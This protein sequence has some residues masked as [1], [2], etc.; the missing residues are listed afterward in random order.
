MPAS[1]MVFLVKSGVTS[2]C[3]KLVERVPCVKESLTMD[4]IIERIC[5]ETCLKRKVRMD[6]GRITY[7]ENHEGF[8]KFYQHVQEGKIRRLWD[9]E[10][11]QSV[12]EWVKSLRRLDTLS[13]RKTIK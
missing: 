4:V 12:E 7:L 10:E 9:C 11:S 3:L 6:R 2:D 1:T 8:W 5:I 13:V